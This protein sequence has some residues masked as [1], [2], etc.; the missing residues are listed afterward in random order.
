MF[1]FLSYPVQISRPYMT[2]G[3][4]I[5]FT[6]RTFVGKV[7]SLLLNMLSSARV[8]LQKPGNQ[9]EGMSGISLWLKVLYVYFKLQIFFYTLTKAWGQR[10]DNFSFPHPD[11]FSPEIIV[12]LQIVP[13]SEILSES[14]LLSI[15]Y[16]LLC[17]L[18]L[19]CD[20]IVTHATFLSLF[21]IFLNPV[22]P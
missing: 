12:A 13:A 16:F 7:M 8:Q 1:S 20:Y 4:T 5:A 3:K 6:R 17:V 22:C 11:L 21:L 14:A 15:I 2:T 9:P 18:Y 19:T 10:F